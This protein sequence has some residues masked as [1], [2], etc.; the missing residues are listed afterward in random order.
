M[1]RIEKEGK[2]AILTIGKTFG[3]PTV[4]LR[5]F[6][7]YGPRQALSNPYTGCCAIFSSRIMNGNPPYIFED[8]VQT[9]DFVYVAEVAY[10]NLLALEKNGGN[11]QALNV[12][13]GKLTS[14]RKL[15]ELLLQLLGSEL[16]PI[17]SHEYRAGDI[18]HCYAD[19]T[20]IEKNSDLNRHFNRKRGCPALLSG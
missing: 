4:A 20:R 9:R 17:I 7:V 5:Y 3:I 15:A 11:Y 13:T 8:G 14:I 12:G 6:N 2:V 1:G 16:K 18:R 19:I 10:A